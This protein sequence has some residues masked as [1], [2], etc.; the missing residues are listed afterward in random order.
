MS[1]SLT[2]FECPECGAVSIGSATH[3]A[4][5]TRPPK[6]PVLVFREEVV[7]PLYEAAYTVRQADATMSEVTPLMAAHVA[8]VV[9]AF[10]ALEGWK[11]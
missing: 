2:I 5:C 4:A 8:D 9:D 11:R 3:K 6:R 10:P 1:V 7:R